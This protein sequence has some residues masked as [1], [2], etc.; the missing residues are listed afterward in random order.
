MVISAGLMQG[1]SAAARL[2]AAA[3]PVR[4]L[5]GHVGGRDRFTTTAAEDYL[6][7][8]FGQAG[9]ALAGGVVVDRPVR[10]DAELPFCPEP[11][12]AVPT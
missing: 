9:V 10:T 2:L 8:G 7:S 11:G 5:A 12:T 3:G 1:L 6:R 4:R